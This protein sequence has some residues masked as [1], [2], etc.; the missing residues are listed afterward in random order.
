MSHGD[1]GDRNCEWLHWCLW[2]FVLCDCVQSIVYTTSLG[3]LKKTVF[4]QQVARARMSVTPMSSPTAV[5][6]ADFVSR[7]EAIKKTEEL[8]KVGARASQTCHDL[9][10]EVL[11]LVGNCLISC[12]CLHLETS[13]WNRVWMLHNV[14]FPNQAAVDKMFLK[15]WFTC[16]WAVPLKMLIC[17]HENDSCSFEV[18][19]AAVV[20][21]W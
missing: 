21:S 11:L 2:S 9:C 7:I 6:S 5:K 19:F 1:G 3:N 14:L 18:V 8:K 13:S 17:L 20:Y 10:W 12:V 4:N 16:K 15:W